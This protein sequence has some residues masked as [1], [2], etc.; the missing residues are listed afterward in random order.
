MPMCRR[1]RLVA[2]FSLR[3]RRIVV[4]TSAQVAAAAVEPMTRRSLSS[5]APES[6][7]PAAARVREPGC[8]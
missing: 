1:T 2:R 3:V 8:N 4:E 5:Q 7:D 6:C